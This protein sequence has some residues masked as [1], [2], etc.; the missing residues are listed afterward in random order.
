MNELILNWITDLPPQLI[1]IIPLLALLESVVF[2]GLFVS[3]IFLLSTCTLIYAQGNTQLSVIVAL[4]FSG[5]LAG[6][7]LGYFL[8][9]FAGPRLWQKKWVRKQIIKRKAPYRKFRSFLI[10][11]APIAICVGRLS[12]P[13]R[14]VSPLLAGASGLRP[15]QFFIYDVVACCIWAVGLTLLVQVAASLTV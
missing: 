6:D 3:G 2:I 8:G 14:S 4:A 11:S 13:L 15:L 10:K 7:H 12:P 9:Y 1:L 5:A